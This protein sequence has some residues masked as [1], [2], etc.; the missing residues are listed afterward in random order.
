M[1]KILLC[2]LVQIGVLAGVYAQSSDRNYVITQTYKTPTGSV[3]GSIN[4]AS[5]E[6]AYFDGL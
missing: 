5:Q 2:S 3:S 1:R 4:V 6:V